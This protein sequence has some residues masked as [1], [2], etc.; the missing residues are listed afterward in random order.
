MELQ[1]Y[2]LQE[3]IRLLPVGG[4]LM[5]EVVL[6]CHCKQPINKATDDYVLIEKATNRYPEVLAHAACEQKRASS[7]YGVNFEELMKRFWRWPGRP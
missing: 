1:A 3:W 5:P 7:G 6:C 2:V 4:L